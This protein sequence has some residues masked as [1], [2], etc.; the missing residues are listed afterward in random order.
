MSAKPTKTK[1]AVLFI[2]GF[3]LD[4]RIWAGQWELTDSF[5]L[6]RFD[7]PGFGTA[8]QPVRTLRMYDYAECVAR[9]MD[10]IGLRRA[11]ISCE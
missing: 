6:V 9:E 3:P 10:R 1:P 4:S 2:H 7:L 8:T 5:R 11:T